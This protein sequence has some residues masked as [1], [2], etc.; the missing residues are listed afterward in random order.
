MPNYKPY[1]Y[2]QSAMVV[3][4]YEDQ[5]QPGTFEHAVHFLIDRKLD[6]SIFDQHYSNDAGGRPAYDPAIL[7]KVI[8]FAY[9]KGI[10]SSREIQWCC[11]SNVIFKALSCGTVPHFTTI[12]AFIS[13]YPKEIEAIFEQV[14]LICHQQGL[15]GNE[16]F[17][18]DGCKMPSNAAKEW[19]GTFRELEAKQAKIKRRIQQC[20]DAHRKLDQTDPEQSGQAQRTERTIETLERAHERIDQFLKAQTPRMGQGRRSKEIKSNI[21]DNES[22][23]MTTGKGT[24]QGYNG[25]AAVD[26]K[27]QIV[28]DAQAFGHGQEQA[29]LAPVLEAMAARY[30]RLGIRERLFDED[31]VVTADTGFASEPNMQ[32]LHEGRINAYVPDHQFRSRDP[33]FQDQKA[34]YG[35]RRLG[36]RSDQFSASEFGFDPVDMSCV[37]PDGK[38]LSLRGVRDDASGQPVAYFEG[39]LSQCGVCPVKRR[40]MRNPS[41]SG[42]GR[43]VSFRLEGK[44]RPTYTDWM[45]HRVDSPRGK[46]IYSQ[47]LAVVE[48][49]FGNIGSNKGLSRF[50]LRGR[51][52]VQTQWRLYCLVHNIE[53]LKNY[54]HLWD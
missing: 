43:Q 22:A 37:C 13:G 41:G 33:R 50:S 18:L 8:L 42:H 14:L 38:A 25:I 5:L 54:G 30:R 16:L 12:A 36:R 10:T 53:K 52:K 21:T 46:A 26:H 35:R 32:Y 29:T 51:S 6:L 1:N 9:S 19:S 34:K 44:G 11:E 27:H 3:I 47:R 40:C 45:K 7:L 31:T 20:L 17:A 15:L 39:R 4:N 48:P 23:K 24:I 2:D 49:V 28:V